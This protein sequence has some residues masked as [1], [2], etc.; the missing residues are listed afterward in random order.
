VIATRTTE[1]ARSVRVLLIEDEARLAE[2]IARGL[3]QAAHAVD[4]ADRL[5]TAREKLELERYDAII[6]DVNLPDGSGFE[7]AAEL[8]KGEDPV[9]ILML[10]ARDSVEDR[11][12][13]LDSGADDYLVKPFAFDELLAR[14][15]A[16][17][18]RAP[19]SRPTALRIHDLTLDPA[20]RSVTRA[21]QAIELTT[22]EYALLDYLARHVGEVCGR[23]AISGS[24]WDENYDPFSNIIDVYVSRLRRKIDQPG[25]VALIHTVRGAGYTLDPT[26]GPRAV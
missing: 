19:D 16:L 24:V 9:P 11:V 5:S 17:Q 25:L 20:A 15:R 1:G 18:R 26:R 21:G 4:V 12:A 7:L 6:L 10:T 13:G 2:S 14:L 23:A 8:R 22:T 3:R